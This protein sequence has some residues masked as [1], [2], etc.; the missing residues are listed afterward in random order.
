MFY[1]VALIPG[2]NLWWVVM[3][4]V[5]GVAALFIGYLMFDALRG[6]SWRRTKEKERASRM[7]ARSRAGR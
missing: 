5:T 4:V 6:W 2:F 1:P 3:G 7:R